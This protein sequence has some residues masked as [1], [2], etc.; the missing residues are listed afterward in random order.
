MQFRKKNTQNKNI[1]K[2]RSFVLLLADNECGICA[3]VVQQLHK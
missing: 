2:I 1:F 3:Q